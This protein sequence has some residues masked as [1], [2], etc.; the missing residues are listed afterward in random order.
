MPDLN[1]AQLAMIPDAT[2][3]DG[4]G[5][6][7]NMAQ[8]PMGSEDVPDYANFTPASFTP[9]RQ[10]N[11][12]TEVVVPNLPSTL[13]QVV[14]TAIEMSVEGGAI[15]TGFASA[16]AGAPGTDGTRP[17]GSVVL[18]SG[19]AYGGLET[20]SPGVIVLAGSTNGASSSARVTKG[21]LLA[22]RTLVA[23]FL[24]VPEGST[25]SGAT[26]VFSPGQPQ[27]ASVY[28]TGG[29]LARV[30]ISGTQTRHTIYFTVQASQTSVALPP[31]PMGPGKDPTTEAQPQ[32]DVVTI[33]LSSSIL[34]TDDAFT[35]A[36]PNLGALEQMIDGYSRFTR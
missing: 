14:L 13:N 29:E 32:L 34:A 35:L 16:T 8:C 25:Y 5:L 28:S 3:V 11:R 10:Q 4:D 12:R 15:P 20:S 1:V 7:T 19:P 26:R 2:D 23:P 22:P 27:W 6:C 18:R 30:S 17:V 21:P 31:M 9:Q 36:G 24:P 33:D